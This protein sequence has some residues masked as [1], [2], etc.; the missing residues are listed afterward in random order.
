MMSSLA[1]ALPAL[2]GLGVNNYLKGEFHPFLTPA[3]WLRLDESIFPSRSGTWL[4]VQVIVKVTYYQTD[5]IP[6]RR[7][8]RNNEE[9]AEVLIR[10]FVEV[11][12]DGGRTAP[13]S[14]VVRAGRGSEGRE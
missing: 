1:R 4:S 8:R 14:V 13:V 12:R 2:L 7:R 5:G 6:G 11:T 3:T 10:R 9:F